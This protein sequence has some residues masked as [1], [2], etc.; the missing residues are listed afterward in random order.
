M[1]LEHKIEIL[2]EYLSSKEVYSEYAIS[3]KEDIIFFL[4]NINDQAEKYSFLKKLNTKD[5]IINKIDLLI[6][7]LIMHEEDAGTDYL[8]E[9]YLFQ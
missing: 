5:E 7:K 4:D 1:K 9:E 8:I 6:T 2:N 3:K